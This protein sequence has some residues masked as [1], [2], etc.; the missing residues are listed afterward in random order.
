M[1]QCLPAK[2]A[3]GRKL[4]KRPTLRH[5]VMT[6]QSRRNKLLTRRFGHGVS[7]GKEELLFVHTLTFVGF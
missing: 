3:A 5:S 4:C 6:S 2:L 1:L 7:C